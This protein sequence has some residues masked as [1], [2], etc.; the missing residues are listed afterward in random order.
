VAAGSLSR[1]RGRAPYRKRKPIPAII[2]VALLGITAIVVWVKVMHKADNVDAAVACPTSTVASANGQ[3]LPYGALDKVTPAVPAQISYRVY[4][5][6]SQRG[7]AQQVAIA[8]NGLGF[9]Q[10]ATVAD[11]PLYPK[12][13]LNCI[14]ELRF[15]ANGQ[16]AARTLSL[17]LPCTELIKDN[18]QDATVDVS[19]G[20][21][22]SSVL[23]NKDAM[24]A[25]HQLASWASSHPTPQGGQ[26]AQGGQAPQLSPA[27]LSGA[28]TTVC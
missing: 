19:V 25:L 26:Q 5:G 11:D 1:E 28:H 12:Q 27:L 9:Q 20:K 17:V 6:S 3:A 7:A 18:R 15:G 22:F 24:S 10:P 4:N 13:D 2:I 23:P 14:G 21:N 16:A 8:L